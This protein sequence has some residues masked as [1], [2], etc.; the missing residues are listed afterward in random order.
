[1]SETANQLRQTIYASLMAAFIAAGAFISIPLGPVPITLQTLF[2]LLTGLLLGFKWG[3]GAIGV[4][5]LAG[6][7]GLPVFSQGR[8]GFAHF[9]GPTGG[10]LIGFIAA[11]CVVGLI[12]DWIRHRLPENALSRFGLELLAVTLGTATIYAAGV[13]WLKT[14]AQLPWETALSLGVIPF[15]I[16]DLVKIFATVMIARIVR[17]LMNRSFQNSVPVD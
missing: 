1:M 11:V 14:V 9:L 7:V 4:Y 3:L 16:G 12:A 6:T 5:L 2:V 15:L 13:P 8:G 17:P 10:Y